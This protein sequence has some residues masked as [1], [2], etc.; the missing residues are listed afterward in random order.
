MRSGGRGGC[1]LRSAPS[2]LFKVEIGIERK[3]W[4][5][6]RSTSIDIC[7]VNYKVY[8]KV[9]IWQK[10]VF[11]RVYFHR[12]TLPRPRGSSSIRPDQCL[13][14]SIKMSISSDPRLPVKLTFRKVIL[15]WNKINL[16][17]AK[18]FSV[19]SEICQ[20]AGWKE[21]NFV[22]HFWDGMSQCNC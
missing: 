19:F 5:A 3:N 13:R 17:T 14:T 21:T 9:K 4:R 11:Q 6:W 8:S 22:W 1:S 18:P 7:N 10:G 15:S 2:Y 20:T 16:I 12:C